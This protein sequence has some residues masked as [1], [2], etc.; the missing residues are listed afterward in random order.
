MSKDKLKQTLPLPLLQL[1]HFSEISAYILHQG[2]SPVGLQVSL[3]LNYFLVYLIMPQALST[4][5]KKPSEK[6]SLIFNFPLTEWEW[7][8]MLIKFNIK[9]Q[10]ARNSFLLSSESVAMITFTSLEQR[11]T[12]K[13]IS[14]T[15]KNA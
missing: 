3:L 9:T 1:L 6:I 15:F 10:F 4:A 5:W 7:G 8:E 2:N 12:A 14:Q 11:K 13:T